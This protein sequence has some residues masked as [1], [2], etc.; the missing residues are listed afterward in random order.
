M[1][2]KAR[3]GTVEVKRGEVEEQEVGDVK[4]KARSGIVGEG[5]EVGE[6]RES[7]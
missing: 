1:K 2:W 6:R 5:R 7:R 3:R 4:V